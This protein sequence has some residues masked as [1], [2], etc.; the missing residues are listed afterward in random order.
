MEIDCGVCR[1]RAWRAG[2]ETSLVAHANDRDIWL[3]LRDRFP[4]PYTPED[5][6][7]WVT[8][9]SANSESHLAIEVGG[10]AAGGIGFEL[11]N[12]VDRVSAEIG[13]WLGRKHWGRGIM[14]AAVRGATTYAFTIFGITRLFALP[15]ATNRA[16]ARVLEK[17]GYVREGFLRRS[18]I[19]D[20]VVLDQVLYAI[21]DVDLFRGNRNHLREAP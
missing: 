21:T 16:S 7:S 15:Y 5:A 1:L 18:V 19:K 4:H 3:N 2:D 11:R 9:A 12:D 8:L 6:E 13:Y 20:G 10:E 14:S 17:A